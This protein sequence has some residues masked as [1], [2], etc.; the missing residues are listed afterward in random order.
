MLVISDLVQDASVSIVLIGFEKVVDLCKQFILLILQTLYLLELLCHVRIAL[1]I[2]ERS[3]HFR[4]KVVLLL[5]TFIFLNHVI[6]LEH[7]ERLN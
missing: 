6:E 7:G 3:C 5:L 1:T 2:I 4:N